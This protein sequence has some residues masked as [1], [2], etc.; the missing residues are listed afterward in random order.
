ML[1][2]IDKQGEFAKKIAPF[3]E[4]LK[5]IF[6]RTPKQLYPEQ[7][8]LQKGTIIIVPNKT[9][10]KEVI[11]RGLHNQ[12]VVINYQECTLENLLSLT[13]GKPRYGTYIDAPFE[14]L[15]DANSHS[16]ELNKGAGTPKTLDIKNNF[17][18]TGDVV[19]EN[20]QI[21]RRRTV[22]PFE[23]IEKPDARI[24][25]GSN[26]VTRKGEPGFIE[27]DFDKNTGKRIMISNIKAPIA[28]QVRIGTKGKQTEQS[29]TKSNSQEPSISKT[30]QSVKSEPIK[31]TSLPVLNEDKELDKPVTE[32]N[33]ATDKLGNKPASDV[34]RP[35]EL[36]KDEQQGERKNNIS[37]QKQNKQR[38]KSR[39]KNRDNRSEQKKS[40]K[41]NEQQKPNKKLNRDNKRSEQNVK[42]IAVVSIS[43][44]EQKKESTPQHIKPQNKTDKL[45]DSKPTFIADGSNPKIKQELLDNV[46]TDKV[47][48]PNFIADT[49]PKFIDESPKTDIPNFVTQDVESVKPNFIKDK[50]T[51]APT[52]ITEKRESPAPVFIKEQVET[53]DFMSEGGFEPVV[54]KPITI[55][56][57]KADQPAPKSNTDTVDYTQVESILNFE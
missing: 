35:V 38:D 31:E 15:V 53:P 6:A 16:S 25:V 17:V 48:V 34:K 2:I 42:P 57:P 43:K 26:K 27:E 39:K 50:S 8:Y 52:F 30:K 36:K 54:T 45:I 22:I 32:L 37:Y 21:I 13:K 29:Q 18:Q 24:S 14:S 7:T 5:V 12:I 40:F 19:F 51:P 23:V 49:A 55:Y 44:T 47:Q 10:K 11:E 3:A 41:Q 9:I 33:K 4:E 46:V 1:L 20:E 28:E 56:E